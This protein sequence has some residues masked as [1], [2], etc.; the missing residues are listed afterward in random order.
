MGDPAAVVSSVL[1][2]HAAA[3]LSNST[4]NE[5]DRVCLV[6]YGVHLV[7][8]EAGFAGPSDRVLHPRPQLRPFSFVSGRAF[9]AKKAQCTRRAASGSRRQRLDGARIC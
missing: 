5:G 2:T 6:D 9:E 8:P 1:G 3:P 4:I 7:L